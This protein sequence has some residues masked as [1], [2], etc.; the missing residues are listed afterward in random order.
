MSE[1]L[2]LLQLKK[3]ED[4]RLRA[5]HLWIYSNEVDTKKTPLSAFS[6]G[7]CVSVVSH[8]GKPLGSAYINPH[9]LICAR[10]YSHRA[11][12]YFDQQLITHRLQQALQL[13][14]LLYKEPF[15]RLCYGESDF[16]PGIVI[17]RFG[18]YLVM[19]LNTVG[20]EAAR[21]EIIAALQSVVQPR[22]ILLRND[23]GA[24]E[25]EGL[26]SHIEVAAGDMPEAIE[27][28]E[29]NTHLMINPYTSQKT[30]WYYDH[31]DNR[32]RLQH[33]A[34]GKRV[35]DV[36]SYVGA[37]GIEALQAGAAQVV[38]V[39]ASQTALQQAQHNA[40][41]NAVQER[42]QIRAGDAFEALTQ[43]RDAG[44]RFDIVV[45]D[46]PAFVKRRKDLHAGLR[47]Y[48]QINQLALQLLQHNGLLVSASCSYHVSADMLLAEIRN[49]TKP[50]PYRLQIIEQGH[51]GPDHPVHPAM[52]ETA[53]IKAFFCRVVSE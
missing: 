45:V 28:V 51:Q 52:P 20:A 9:S 33:Y 23:S 42:L 3:D 49:A 2:A 19:Q 53:Y 13:R 24:R 46:P 30:G 14:E 32:K 6:A 26:E 44:E 12:Q 25:L 43:L 37:W 29:N 11:N 17:D 4:R 1:Q 7:Q 39:D 21:S 34:T 40:S 16:L 41:L 50:L 22:G 31:R 8:Q 27:I 10:I 48:A 35:L 38:C 15:Y 5:G 36:F 18:D 47:A